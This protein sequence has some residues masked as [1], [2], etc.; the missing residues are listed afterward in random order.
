VMSPLAAVVGPGLARDDHPLLEDRRRARHEAWLLVPRRP[1]PV[2]RVVRELE[3]S[4]RYRV[5]LLGRDARRD[6]GLHLL[7]GLARERVRLAHLRG[8][9]AERESRTRVAPV[10]RDPRDEVDEHEVAFLHP[11]RAP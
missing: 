10:P 1:E 7:E 9:L 6:P 11:P 8:L 3:P 5:A 2:A 4:P